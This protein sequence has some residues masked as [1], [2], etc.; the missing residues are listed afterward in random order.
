MPRS[1]QPPPGNPLRKRSHRR[2]GAGL[3]LWVTLL[4]PLDPA[5]AQPAAALSVSAPP[6]G[7]RLTWL[8]SGTGLIHYGAAPWR[9]RVAPDSFR[10]D[11]LVA[12]LREASYAQSDRANHG[13]IV[14]TVSLPGS[15]ELRFIDDASVL[16]PLL[17]RAWAARLAPAAPFE[18]KAHH[19]Q[20]ASACGFQPPKPLRETRQTFRI[21]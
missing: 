9:V 10:F 19:H 21:K 16:P 17:E 12:Q 13:D 4:S 2:C 7:C 18:S 3:A 14:G 8:A 1:P 5:H 11:A 20:I 15:T 6:G